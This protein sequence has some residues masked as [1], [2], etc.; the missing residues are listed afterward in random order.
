MPCCAI[1]NKEHYVNAA[2]RLADEIPGGIFMNQFENLANFEAHITETGPEI[3]QQMHGNID[4]F[5]MSAGTGGTIAGVSTFLKEKNNS[6]RVVLGDPQ[7]SSLFHR[8]MHGVCFTVEQT[9]RKVRKHRYDS[10]VEGVGLDR[11]TENFKKA[12]IDSAEKIM[13]QEIIEMAHWLVREE[14]LFVGSS[15]ALNIAAACR[16][17]HKIGYGHTVVTIVCDSGQRHLS[18]FWNPDYIKKYN[19]TWPEIDSLPK[20]LTLF[21]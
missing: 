13:D 1:S 10:I 18:R 11:V 21:K 3:W 2:R 17:A 12:V 19:L 15:S 6:L 8:V 4:A 14:G 16:T 9:E 7:G 20:C 5:V